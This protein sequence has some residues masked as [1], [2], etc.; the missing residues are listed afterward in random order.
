MSLRDHV[1]CD[2]DLH[3]MEPP[4]LWERYIDPAYAHAAPRGMSEIPRDMRV[5]VKNS[6]VL[7]LPAVR[8]S[9]TIVPPGSGWRPEHDDA[10]AASEA[11]GWDAQSEVDAMDAEGLD[12]AVLFP[13]RGLFVLGIDSVEQMGIDGLEPEYA[14]AIARAY[15]DW[16]KDFCDHAPNRMFGA[17]MVAP[18]DVP[19]AVEEARRCVEDLGF[20]SIFLAPATVNRRPW[21][22]PAYDPLWAEIERLDVPI[23]FHGGGQTYLTPDF[24]LE[25]LD[26][27]MLWHT[28]SQPLGIQFVTVCFCGGGI[29]E[30]FPNLRVALLEGNCSWAPWLLYRLDEH[31]EWTGSYEAP[32]LTMPPSEYFKR[33]CWVSVEADEEPVPHFIS[34]FGDEKLL[35]STDYPHGDSK[36]PHAV[37]AFDKLPISDE[38]KA[39]IVSTNWADLYKIPLTKNV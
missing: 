4:D 2:S 27:L 34:T 10:Y 6:V 31:Y 32:D 29:L 1:I 9:R 28:F 39:R 36:Y 30:R 37:D 17:G 5:K 38:S 24:S 3:V 8:P 21:H 11:R 18:H 20:K 22:H 16:M 14:T 26:K 25:V 12:L 19:G 23:A 13:S 33:N 35:F 15:N 7:R